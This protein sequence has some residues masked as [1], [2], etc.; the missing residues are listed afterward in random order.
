MSMGSWGPSVIISLCVVHV[1]R[2]ISCDC[3]VGPSKLE[4]TT[5]TYNSSFTQ[6][7]THPHPEPYSHPTS[8][9]GS[10]H[11]ARNGATDN[12]FSSHQPHFHNQISHPDASH[13]LNQHVIDDMLTLTLYTVPDYPNYPVAAPAPQFPSFPPGR[14]KAALDW[15]AII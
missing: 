6:H 4:H 14:S 1:F 9:S 3:V 8:P 2:H 7:H 13:S 12:V 5:Q 15:S 10:K 11:S